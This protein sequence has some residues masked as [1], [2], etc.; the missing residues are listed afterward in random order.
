MM[1]INR[2]FAEIQE[3][4]EKINSLHALL[5]EMSF[6]GAF[7]EDYCGDM[8]AVER[9]IKSLQGKLRKLRRQWKEDADCTVCIL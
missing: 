9:N 6:Y 3:I 5:N 4:E 2:T 8:T 7:G 1:Y